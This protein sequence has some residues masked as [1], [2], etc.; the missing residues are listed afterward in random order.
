MA[1]VPPAPEIQARGPFDQKPGGVAPHAL[2]YEKQH[3]RRLFLSIRFVWAIISLLIA[4][5]KINSQLRARGEASLHTYKK[6]RGANIATP[7]LEP[8]T[9]PPRELAASHL[10]AR[11]RRKVDA[12]LLAMS[13]KEDVA[14]V[15]SGK[16]ACRWSDM[17][18][19][20]K[21]SHLTFR[22]TTTPSLSAPS[23]EQVD[24]PPPAAPRGALLPPFEEE[25]LLIGLSQEAIDSSITPS[26]ST[27]TFSNSKRDSQE[28]L[29]SPI[30]DT[31]LSPAHKTAHA[32]PV[33]GYL[34]L[35]AKPSPPSRYAPY[36]LYD[37]AEPGGLSDSRTAGTPKGSLPASH[38]LIPLH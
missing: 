8:H 28:P 20:G 17:S 26:A 7:E 34:L 23:G 6:R 31:G 14:Q 21:P 36:Q 15:T 32:G 4:Q 18:K 1:R 38:P 33:P 9:L 22:F 35:R 37:L 29:A 10:L 30:R 11:N 12:R 19:W 3:L 13:D 5:K 16:A 27:P 2:T 25:E 24:Q